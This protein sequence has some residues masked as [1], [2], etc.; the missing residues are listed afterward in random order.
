MMD[1]IANNKASLQ[2]YCYLTWANNA[3]GALKVRGIIWKSAWT[4]WIMALYLF[5]CYNLKGA[6]KSYEGF[7]R[8]H[9]SI[10]IVVE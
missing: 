5:H 10:V 9:S 3:A 2:H 8:A 1:V 6:L 4:S 7:R